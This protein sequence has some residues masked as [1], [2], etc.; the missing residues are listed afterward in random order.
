MPSLPPDNAREPPSEPLPLWPPRLLNV[1]E[2][3]ASLLDKLPPRLLSVTERPASLPDEPPPTLPSVTERPAAAPV[4][5]PEV[6][7]DAA[8]GNPLPVALRDEL[9]AEELEDDVLVDGP[10][11]ETVVVAEAVVVAVV[12]VMAVVVGTTVTV[13]LSAMVKVRLDD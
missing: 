2:R 4:V 6:D 7:S 1:T 13:L 9:D 8:P 3:P 5:S 12:V 11:P 10:L